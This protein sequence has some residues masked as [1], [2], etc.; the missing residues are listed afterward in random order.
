MKTFGCCP[1]SLV[2][3]LTICKDAKHHSFSE[4]EYADK[5]TSNYLVDLK[6]HTLLESMS[7]VSRQAGFQIPGTP[8]EI[9]KDFMYFHNQN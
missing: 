9:S 3:R 8:P 7:G 4:V 1:S 6:K 2:I 5:N